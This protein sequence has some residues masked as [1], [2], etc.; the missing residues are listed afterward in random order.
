MTMIGYQLSSLKPLLLSAEEVQA[1][2]RRLHALGYRTLQIQWISP[3]VPDEAVACALKETGMDC[4]GVQDRYPAIRE[5]FDRFVNQNRLFGGRDLCISGIPPEN[6]SPEGLRAYAAELDGMRRR[7]SEE[8][9][10]LSFHPIW[11]D[12]VGVDGVPA[13]DRLMDALPELRLTLCAY[14]AVKAGNDPAALLE[15]YRGRVDTVH[16][17][18]SALRPDGS[19]FLVP[20]GQGRIDWPPIFEACNRTGVRWGLAEQERWEKDPFLCAE[21]SYRYICSNGIGEAL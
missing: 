15:R 9:M 14:H 21:E 17:K 2:L 12:Y 18:D 4:I 7:L 13:L 3:E 5:Q 19:D 11:S 16:F 1:A 20:T 8:G 10:T 6:F